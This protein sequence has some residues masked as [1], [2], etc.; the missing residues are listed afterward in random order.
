M[1]A[2]DTNKAGKKT[3]MNLAMLPTGDA[4]KARVEAEQQ[5]QDAINLAMND[6]RKN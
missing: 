3:F 2:Y 5:V 1:L 6:E 4:P